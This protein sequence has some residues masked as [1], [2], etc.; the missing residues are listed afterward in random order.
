LRWPPTLEPPP[1]STLTCLPH[2]INIDFASAEYDGPLKSGAKLHFLAG[3]HPLEIL[4]EDGVSHGCLSVRLPKALLARFGLIKCCFRTAEECAAK[5]CFV[6]RKKT[7]RGLGKGPSTSKKAT[8]RKAMQDMLKTMPAFSD[9][10][11]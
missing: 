8:D 7:N 1:T 9:A 5:P 3:L 2:S 6:A 4:D 11:P 10:R